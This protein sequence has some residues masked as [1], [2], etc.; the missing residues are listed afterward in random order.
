MARKMDR[1]ELEYVYPFGSSEAYM[2]VLDLLL[3]FSCLYWALLLMSFA[4]IGVRLGGAWLPAMLAPPLA[5]TFCLAAI[6]KGCSLVHAV[7]NIDLDIIGRIQETTDEGAFEAIRDEALESFRSKMLERIG[8]ADDKERSLFVCFNNFDL[9]GNGRLNYAELR[10]LTRN[11]NIHMT[12]ATFDFLFRS[13]D[14]KE[15]HVIDYEELRDA[16]FP[17]L[18]LEEDKPDELTSKRSF[19][20]RISNIVVGDRPR[21]RSRSIQ[22][23]KAG[24]RPRSS[25][26]NGSVNKKDTGPLA[27]RP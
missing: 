9:A 20:G 23:A 16:V 22:K 12:Y 18:V 7:A 24:P 2:N 17:D 11:L 13:M 25:M 15:D 10:Q 21:S 1:S 4:R 8:D 3:L 5:W 19:V 27:S 6:V 26:T 14:A